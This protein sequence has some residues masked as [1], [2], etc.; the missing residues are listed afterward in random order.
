MRT[1][2]IWVLF[3]GPLAAQDIVLTGGEAR[4]CEQEVDAEVQH[5]MAV[6]RIR[7]VFENPTDRATEGTYSFRIPEEASLTGFTMWIGAKTMKGQIVDREEA[8][9]IYEGIVA[10]S[11]DPGIVEETA[12]RVFRVR[13]FPIAAGSRMKFEI[14]YV[15]W[16][17]FDGEECTYVYPLRI[18]GSRAK[19]LDR[20]SF[21]LRSFA[22]SRIVDVASS[23]HPLNVSRKSEREVH[24][25]FDN[26]LGL[27]RDVVI[28]YSLGAAELGF[29]AHRDLGDDGYFALFLESP[30]LKCAAISKEIVYLLVVGTH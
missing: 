14:T 29:L 17:P 8:R 5:R 1:F 22:T 20:F 4:L 15:S 18:D 3:V 26:R 11:R 9:R 28:R 7:Q 27:D 6:T 12:P 13:V 25:A 2:T 21:E 24:V 30:S 19:T 10:K 16:L 23:T